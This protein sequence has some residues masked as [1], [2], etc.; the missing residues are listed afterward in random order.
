MKS[1]DTF[2]FGGNHYIYFDCYYPIHTTYPY[3]YLFIVSKTLTI[4]SLTLVSLFIGTHIPNYVFQMTE[5][6]GLVL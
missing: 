1:V 3:Y 5:P 4:L 6:Y 2:F